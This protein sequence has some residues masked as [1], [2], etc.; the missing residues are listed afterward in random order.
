MS[1]ADLI[2]MADRIHTMSDGPA[3]TAIAVAGGVITATGDRADARGWRGRG[4]EVVDLGAAT[5]TP[6]LVDGHFHPVTGVGLTRG[7]DLSSVRTAEG[8]KSALRDADVAPGAWLEGW[9]LDPNVFEGA[10]VTHAPLVE[11]VGPDVPVFLLL[12]DGHAALVSPRALEM[13]GIDGPRAFVSGA[14]VVCDADRRPT[15]HLLEL[16][17]LDLV[18]ALLPGDAPADRRARLTDL[19]RRMAAAGLTAANA[20]DFEADSAALFRSLEE[21][22]ELPV[23]WR[24]APFV[25]PGAGRDGLDA[26]IAQQR[27]AG[28][29]WRVQG[30]K[31]MIDGTIDGGTAWLDEPD[32][33]GESTACLWPDPSAY[34][35]AAGVLA[36]HGIPIVTHAIGD[37]GIRYVLDTY[38]RLPRTSVPHRIEHLETMPTELI[39]RFAS[40]DV[41]ASMQPT[42]CTAYTRADHS[43]NWSSRL[44]KR[45][46]DRAFR[47]RDLRDR[48]ARLVLGSD[49]PIAPFDPRAILAAARLRRPAGR[50]DVEPVLPGQA[51][52]A[53]MAL[54]GYTTEAA[55]A[56][57]LS[58]ESGRLVPGHR[59]DLTVFGLDPLSADPDE[60]AESPVPMTVVGGRVAHRG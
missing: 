48:G 8:L 2:L 20:M 32:T 50:P 31:F 29:R 60:F 40:R 51:L 54:E 39:E 43:D 52:T 55:A 4:T 36:G 22:G 19:L 21:D 46:A 27:L 47:A 41:T 5:I 34:T 59:A 16:E 58:G 3:P 15:G 30:A 56:A 42:H 17:A 14:G 1:V 25:M 12:F 23:R 49:W 53:R 7:V 26:V 11:A 37:A 24:F 35:D 13:A 33:H 38:A 10:P 9:G 45:R 28:R 18:R 44:G 6:G 57:G